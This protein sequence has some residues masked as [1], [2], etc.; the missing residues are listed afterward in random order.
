M[1][2]SH[3][4]ETVVPIWSCGSIKKLVYKNA[5]LP[6]FSKSL[7]LAVGVLCSTKS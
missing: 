7:V 1:K 3:E 6:L 4:A 5:N 2:D